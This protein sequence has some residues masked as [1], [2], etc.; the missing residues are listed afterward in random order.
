MSE[1]T[2]IEETEVEEIDLS[3]IESHYLHLRLLVETIE[4]DALKANKGNKSA[5]VR[6]RKSLRHLKSFTSDFVKFT[7]NKD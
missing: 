2:V 3:T 4:S 6:L 5:G 1:E 7:L